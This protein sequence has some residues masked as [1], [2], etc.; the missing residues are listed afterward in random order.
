KP[1]VHT[2]LHRTVFDS[3]SIRVNPKPTQSEIQP[4]STLATAERYLLMC[5]RTRLPSIARPLHDAGSGT[6]KGRC[7][8]EVFV[9]N[10]GSF[11]C[12]GLSQ[13]DA[14]QFRRDV[15]S[16][17]KAEVGSFAE[18]EA[19]ELEFATDSSQKTQLQGDLIILRDGPQPPHPGKPSRFVPPSVSPQGTVL[20]HYAFSQALSRSTALSALQASLEDYLSSMSSLPLALE[21]TGNPGMSRRTLVKKLGE[22]LRFR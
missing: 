18:P 21:K 2:S 4:I 22:L 13:E 12:C 10:N 1:K 9:F 5:L 20:A 19:E 8:G 14:M 7:E 11:V 17:A 6:G 3:L 16:P 15:L